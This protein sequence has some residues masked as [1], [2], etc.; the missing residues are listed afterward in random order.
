M[1]C[2]LDTNIIYLLAGIESNNYNKEKIKQICQE[3]EC[4]LDLYSIFEIYNNSNISLKDIQSILTFIKK[5]KIRICCNQDMRN[6]FDKSLNLDIVTQENRTNVRNK[7][8][9]GIIPIYAHLYS[10]LATI[11]FHI[12]FMFY[13][14][15]DEKYFKQLGNF[16]GQSIPILDKQIEKSMRKICVQNRFTEKVLKILYH[17]LLSAYFLAILVCDEHFA[18]N[19]LNDYQKY[20]DMLLNEMQK[21]NFLDCSIS[22]VMQ[23]S[24]KQQN[25]ISM[26]MFALDFRR[27]YPTTADA[28]C[29]FDDMAN[30]FGSENNKEE[31]EWFKQ[32]LKSRLFD[33]AGLRSND[34]IDYLILKNAI[35]ETKVDLLLTCD[36][37]M[38]NI[39]K[40]MEFN[41]KIKSSLQLI[42]GMK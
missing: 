2:L 32:I 25:H 12:H 28:D 9:D 8:A 3:N 39:M 22:F 18:K 4:W 38:Q 41:S 37:R 16:V 26:N 5:N 15:A 33:E 34:F 42:D 19:K 29:F 14:N 1:I 27:E 7:L 21:E 23:S 10:V 6:T 13:K 35:I 17:N 40:K 36:G 31:K 20:F 24:H 30:L 11:N